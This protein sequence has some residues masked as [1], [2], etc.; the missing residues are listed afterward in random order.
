RSL[1]AL[2]RKE[3]GLQPFA[4]G[5]P[6][7]QSLDIGAA[8]DEGE[9]AGRAGGGDAQGVGELDLVEAKQLAGCHRGTERADRTGR[10]ESAP[11]Q[12]AMTGT[13]RA[14]GG[15]V[16]GNDSRKQRLAVGAARASDGERGRNDDAAAVG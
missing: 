15:L 11:A 16:A 7:V 5:M 14:D 12:I 8:I 1:D 10:V 4:R 9:Q 2:V 13:R 3:R 6:G